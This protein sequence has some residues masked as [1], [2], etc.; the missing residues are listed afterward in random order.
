[1]SEQ[2]RP[3]ADQSRPDADQ[4]TDSPVSRRRLLTTTAATAGALTLGI[5]GTAAA[6]Q[7]TGRFN[8]AP[9]RGGQAVVPATDFREK[10]FH[11]TGRTGDTA[12]EIDGALFSCNKGDGEQIFLVGWFFEYVDDDEQRLLF[13]RS[14]NIDT[15]KTYTWST[16]GAKQCDDSGIVLS[17]DG[18]PEDFVQTSYRATGAQ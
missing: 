15:D 17:G 6:S 9:G 3:D 5:P 13:T 2:S 18:Q 1:M 10:A 11:I 7:E 16:Q 14:N 4:S 8:D 12:T